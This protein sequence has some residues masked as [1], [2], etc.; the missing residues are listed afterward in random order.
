M[1]IYS[2][3]TESEKPQP[4]TPSCAPKTA[5]REIFSSNKKFTYKI[6]RNPLKVQQDELDCRYKTASGRSS[7]LGRD[8]IEESGGVNLYA[9]VGND[10]ISYWDMLGY[11]SSDK[12]LAIASMQ[13]FVSDMKN[14]ILLNET[15]LINT[16][17]LLID[18]GNSS[19]YLTVN[20]NAAGNNYNHFRH[21][22][23]LKGLESQISKVFHEFAH[24]YNGRNQGR[25]Y[26]HPEFTEIEDEGIAY[27]LDYTVQV[28][29]KAMG[30]EQI[31]FEG[32][33]GDCDTLSSRAQSAYG[34]MWAQA[35]GNLIKVAGNVDYDLTVIDFNSLF[36]NI[37]ETDINCKYIADRLNTMFEGNECCIYFSC[38]HT[39][40]DWDYIE[41][42]GFRD[43]IK[44]S[45][46]LH[47]SFKSGWGE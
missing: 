11:N 40:G 1:G 2:T 17:G 27:A 37:G 3:I 41:N 14:S 28:A 22:I 25:F 7:W 6:E 23:N 34:Q 5:S 21:H 33:G 26:S 10:P 44:P 30:I 45:L 8:P 29:Q 31:F 35:Y 46:E 19:A 20:A 15:S 39:L 9:F 13:G 43:V 38:D 47:D 12:S 42:V 32:L 16:A 4:E 24:A 18:Y 36:T